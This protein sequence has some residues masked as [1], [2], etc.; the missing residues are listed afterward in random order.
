MEK[1]IWQFYNRASSAP[2]S[3]PIIPLLFKT[4]VWIV[5]RLLSYTK[6]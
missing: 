1:L 2:N 5:F 6:I 4:E 3:F